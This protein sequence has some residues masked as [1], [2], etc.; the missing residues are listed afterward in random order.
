MLAVVAAYWVKRRHRSQPLRLAESIPAGV[1]Q[2]VSGYTFTRS[3]GG[4]QIF[5][6]RAARTRA[7]GQGGPTVLEDVSIEVF[8]RSGNR[9]D[10]VRAERCQYRAD[11]GRLS[12][13]GKVE[14]LL[15][16]PRRQAGESSRL[17]GVSPTLAAA[18]RGGAPVR[19]ETSNVS[20]EQPGSL[21]ETRDAVRWEFG[22]ASGCALGL[23]Y[24]TQDEWLD[25]K[26]DVVFDVPL[27]ER[28]AGPP[29]HGTAGGLHF[30]RADRGIDLRA[31]VALTE[32]G[33]H[34]AAEAG[35]VWLNA[36]FRP[37]RARLKGALRAWDA[38]TGSA[39]QAAA[40]E[41][42]F[43]PGG[44]ALA[45][46]VFAGPVK[47]EW[48]RP[49]SSAVSRL[50]AQD[51]EVDFAGRHFDPTTAMARG[52]VEIS[53]QPGGLP[54]VKGGP[55]QTPRVLRQEAL[56]AAEVDARF[57]PRGSGL[58]Q[59]QTAGPGKIVLVPADPGQGRRIITAGQF[60]MSFDARSRLQ[61]VEGLAPTQIV[62]E[63]VPTARG[64]QIP[65]VSTG[66]RLRAD[67]EPA[68][69]ALRSLTQ[70]G[71]VHL[72][73]GDRQ[74]TAGEAVYQAGS[75]TL[76]LTGG[77][78]LSQPDARLR[79]DQIIVHLGSEVAEG[80]G[81]VTSTHFG[82]LGSLPASAGSSPPDGEAT[83]VVADRV[84]VD[85]RAQVAHYEGH[86]RAWHGYDVI[87]SPALDIYWGERRVVSGAGVVTSDL[88]P[89]LPPTASREAPRARAAG[90]PVR[91]ATIRADRLEYFDL[92]RKARYE[93][94][95]RLNSGDA[96][97]VAD[98]LD[99]YFS[100]SGAAGPSAIERA[101]ADGHVVVTQ[102]ERRATGEHAEYLAA[103]GK[104]VL[105]GGPPT[106]SDTDRG[107][108]TGQ[109]L[110]F[111]LHDDSLIVEGGAQSPTISQHRVRR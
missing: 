20:F 68:T 57:R 13:G 34:L 111:F 88:Q 7:Y 6:V 26:R 97:L 32:G 109:S 36:S 31:P 53:S 99:V 58:A 61:S 85:R 71:H 12:C 49:G 27:P 105:T 48:R 50:A 86:V 33:R 30:A 46:L 87:E 78:L 52:A 84:V 19:L 92:E 14:L 42:D 81:R 40:A 17:P 18:A 72:V 59:M 62:A 47:G 101:V 65:V 2:Q 63:P 35:R 56:T 22:P 28:P 106:L 94:H 23:A 54:P 103:A 24:N 9:H 37:A 45:K 104:V 5:T 108:I 77:P 64:E 38:A 60:L 82:A 67:L 89:S 55:V 66:D 44:E 10:W 73:E 8:G 90:G 16:S 102:P 4:R 25:L 98:R 83:H 39:L 3:E 15:N 70:S 1:N 110:T 80:R 69:A 29:L 76:T 96:T 79:A 43:A 41:A 100:R 21:V 11:S 91:P 107:F 51:V 75:E 74:A 93:G 95:V